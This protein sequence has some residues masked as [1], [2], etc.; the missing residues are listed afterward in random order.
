MGK[1]IIILV[2]DVFKLVLI[3]DFT[4]LISEYPLVQCTMNNKDTWIEKVM[5]NY[6]MFY[7]NGPLVVINEFITI[8]LRLYKVN[9]HIYIF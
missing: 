8:G 6:K 5:V 1:N 3:E 4:K 2:S 7:P 9:I